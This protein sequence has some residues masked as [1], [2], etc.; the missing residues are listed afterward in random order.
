MNQ[1]SGGEGVFLPGLTQR[2][3]EKNRGL[4]CDKKGPKR[5]FEEKKERGGPDEKK[6]K[7][8]PTTTHAE[9]KEGP[10][11]VAW[12]R[13]QKYTQNPNSAEKKTLPLAGSRMKK[14][15][16][17][18][19]LNGGAHDCGKKKRGEGKFHAFK[20]GGLGRGE[21]GWIAG[22]VRGGNLGKGEGPEGEGA[23]KFLLRAS[24]KKKKKRGKLNR[25]NGRRGASSCRDRTPPMRGGGR[26][27]SALKR[28]TTKKGETSFVKNKS[29]RRGKNAVSI[30]LGR[31]TPSSS[32]NELYC[33]GQKRGGKKTTIPPRVKKRDGSLPF[34]K[35]KGA[36]LG[37]LFVPLGRE[38]GKSFLGTGTKKD[39]HSRKGESGCTPS[40][41]EST[42]T[43]EA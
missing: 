16:G 3:K 9:E 1:H 11:P 14:H 40:K 42:P 38:G 10:S 39:G 22:A 27:E 12:R 33:G 36:S 24:R 2:K 7:G 20:E 26:D 21:K 41:K 8:G 29:T 37:L 25:R 31:G 15:R 35:G 13:E 34:H 17:P 19:S 18:S 28:Q 43:Q 4:V 6:K 23:H 32:K 30:P 5:K